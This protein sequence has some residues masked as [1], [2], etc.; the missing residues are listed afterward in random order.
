MR[1]KLNEG[2]TQ[3]PLKENN[4]RE[5]KKAQE[6]SELSWKKNVDQKNYSKY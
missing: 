6:K 1:A 4:S 3:T 2:K 5:I